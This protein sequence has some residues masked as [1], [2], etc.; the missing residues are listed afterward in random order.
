LA[1]GKT[2]SSCGHHGE[3]YLLQHTFKSVPEEKH[4]SKHLNAD[5]PRGTLQPNLDSKI[6]TFNEGFPG[7]QDA[8]L[9]TTTKAFLWYFFLRKWHLVKN[10]LD[11]I[12]TGG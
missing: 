5:K 11:W 10:R 1:E 8:S 12:T 7:Q 6:T 9:S 4:K 3:A 2:N